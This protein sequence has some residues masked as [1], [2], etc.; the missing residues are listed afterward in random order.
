MKKSLSLTILLI[1]LVSLF[2]RTYKIV[3]RFG[4]DHDGDLYSWIIKDVVIN[5]HPRLIGQLTSAPGIYIG[6]AFYYL[7]VPFFLLFKMDPI[8]TIIPL[9]IFGILTTFS[10]FVVFTK[11]FN[12]YAGFIAAFLH[13][14]LL[15]NVDFDRRNVP[16]ST[17]N[18]WTVWY[19]FCIICILRGNFEVLPILGI[20]MGLIWHIH[21]ALIPPLL[22]IPAAIIVSKKL[23]KLKQVIYFLITFFATSLPFLIFEIRHHFIQSSSLILNFTTNHEG[24]TGF[25]KLTQVL[26]MISKNINALFLS[27]Q[28]LPQNL[29]PI[30]TIGLLLLIIPLIL[31][32]VLSVREVI[33]L[34]GWLVGVITFFSLSSSLISEYYFY[35]I[36]IIFTLLVTL[37]FY[38]IFKSSNFGKVLTITLLSL[39]LIKN[40]YFFTT[41]DIYH[42]GYKERKGVAD[43]ISENSKQKGYPCV[44]ISYITT[45]GENVGFRYF[46]YLD[47]LHLVHPSKDIPVYNIVIPDELSKEVKL[48]FGHI[49]VIP[50]TAIPS[51]ETIQKSCQTPNTN[52]T[53]P[54]LGYTE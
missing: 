40:L 31:R 18:F 52:L 50:P 13:A 6:P 28:A 10:Y 38:L 12:K 19:F 32:K 14:V 24:G 7:L 3:D 25:Y 30:F 48:K 54:M 26:N 37:T 9:A 22:A 39:I 53:D 15:A 36:Q 46:F 42:K 2:F 29:Q 16:T 21:I 5:H 8:G 43:F 41:H 35:N 47:N 34:I 51:N 20:L 49:G 27:P 44:G 23:P 11:L 1:L 45:P 4:F 33:P 17:T